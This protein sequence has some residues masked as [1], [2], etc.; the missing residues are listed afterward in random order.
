MQIVVKLPIP[1]DF[2]I[3]SL[4][5]V[6][7][8]PSDSLLGGNDYVIPIPFARKNLEFSFNRQ[9]LEAKVHGYRTRICGYILQ[10]TE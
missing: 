7:H 10:T 4:N 6:P 1:P 3:V 9:K 5:G 2:V 8:C